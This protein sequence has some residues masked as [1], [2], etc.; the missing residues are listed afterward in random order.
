MRMDLNRLVADAIL[1]AAADA[2]VAT[3][4]EGVSST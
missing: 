3:G 4:R 2:V 1:A